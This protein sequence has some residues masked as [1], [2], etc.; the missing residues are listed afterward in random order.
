V[1]NPLRLMNG[2][3]P[4]PIATSF[5]TPAEYEQVRAALMSLQY[6][7][8]AANRPGSSRHLDRAQRARGLR[9]GG[10]RRE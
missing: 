2:Q 6:S 1:P 3:A 10:V 9:Q 7:T 5:L 8:L 4:S